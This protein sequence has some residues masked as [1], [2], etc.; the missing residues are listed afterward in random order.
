MAITNV[1]SVI[2][3][4]SRSDGE[5][6]RTAS[7]EDLEAHRRDALNV[8]YPIRDHELEIY[9]YGADGRLVQWTGMCL[10]DATIDPEKGTVEHYLR[11]QSSGRE[12]KR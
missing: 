10:D 9:C 2:Y 7:V 1:A 4:C 12:V 6:L 11:S 8:H 3:R 5:C